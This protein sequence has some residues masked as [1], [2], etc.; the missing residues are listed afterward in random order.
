VAFFDV[1]V[2][3]D[4]ALVKTGPA[5]IDPW[6]G[7]VFTIQVKN[8]GNVP[9]GDF[10]VLDTIPTGLAATAASR[11][12]C[13]RRSNG[14]VVAHRPAPGAPRPCT[15]TV[16]CRWSTSTRGPWVNYAE[17]SAD[18]ADG[19]DTDR[20]REPGST[21]MWRTTTRCPNVDIADDVLV[22]QT[23]LPTDQFND[24]TVDEDDHDIAPITVIVDY[25]LALVKV[26][27]V[28]QSFKLGS[29]ITFNIVVKNQ[30]NVNSGPVS[31]QDVIPAGLT[32]V[33]ATDG[34][35]TAGAGCHLGPHRLE[36][37]EIKT[38]TMTGQDGRHH[39][40]QLRQLRR[41]R[42]RWCRRLRQRAATCQDDD[43]T[44]DATS[45]TIRWST[46]TTSTSIRS[47][48]T[49]T[50]TTG[51]SSTRPRSDSDN[52]KGGTIPVHG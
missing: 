34:G 10:T 40:D 21:V 13:D 19:Y 36:P 46:P 32:F 42:R 47:R 51:P 5:T 24:P 9:S 35:L 14:D 33:T 37:G 16:M 52:P 29:N 38:I 49:R 26:L 43:S 1:P 22:D 2:L 27:P 28:N 6:R 45:P 23:E 3:Y 17:I 11:W 25:D 31:V 15:V 44:P 41:D 48:V 12:W 50:T 8:Q 18:G 30:G 39:P 7:S 4:L 20:L